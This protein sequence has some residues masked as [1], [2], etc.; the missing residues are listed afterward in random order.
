MIKPG[1]ISS[2]PRRS[3]RP[4]LILLI[5]G[6]L[7]KVHTPTHEVVSKS[8]NIN[9]SFIELCSGPCSTTFR[10]ILKESEDV[11]PSFLAEQ[12]FPDMQSHLLRSCSWPYCCKDW[13][14]AVRFMGWMVFDYISGCGVLYLLDVDSTATQCIF[15]QLGSGIGMGVLFPSIALSIQAS[16]PEED[17]A[18]AAALFCFF[19]G[20][21]QTVGMAIGCVIL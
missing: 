13:K 4:S 3:C 20:F 12:L 19:R 9:L 8:F 14:I 10:C 21:G 2:A 11:I 6:K 16:A 1:N 15:L 5:R 7:R 18:I 17:I